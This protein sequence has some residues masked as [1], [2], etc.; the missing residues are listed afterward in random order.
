M[1]LLGFT[2]Q[3]TD[4]GVRDTDAIMGSIMEIEV[5]GGTVDLVR[6]G[7]ERHHGIVINKPIGSL[8]GFGLP[9]CIPALDDVAE[10]LRASRDSDG[11]IVHSTNLEADF[12]GD[13]DSGDFFAVAHVYDYMGFT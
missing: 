7:A 13:S 6:F 10:D 5:G 9:I 8:G 2:L 11:A 12:T 3:R 1:E 4:I